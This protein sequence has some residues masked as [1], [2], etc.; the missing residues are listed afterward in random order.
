MPTPTKGPRL[1]GSPAHERLM[2]ANLATS[3][4]KHGRITT[5]ETKAKRLRPFAE[6]LITRAKRGDLHS[7]RRVRRVIHELDVVYALRDEIAPRYANRNGGYTRIVKTGPRKGDAAPMAIIELVE[8]LEV[9]VPA[10]AAKATARKAAKRDSMAAL[11]RETDS[12]E[13]PAP[14]EDEPDKA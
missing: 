6:H 11:A 2:L 1:G 3:L 9:A 14:V 10:K 4:F 8:E 12:D 7:L 5:T 13:E